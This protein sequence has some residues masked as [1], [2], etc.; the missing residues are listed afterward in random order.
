[1]ENRAHAIAAGLFTL[2]LLAGVVFSVWW[3]SGNREATREILL[4]AKSRVNGLSIQSQVRFRGLRVGKVMSINI[5]PQPPHRIVVRARVSSNVP[6][7]TSSTA[8][9][10][11]MGVT[12]LSFVQ[13]D[14]EGDG[15]PRPLGKEGL[16]VL[17]LEPSSVES[18]SNSATELASHLSEVAEKLNAFLSPTNA[19]RL[20]RT[21]AHLEGMSAGLEATWKQA[22]LLVADLRR[23]TDDENLRRFKATLANLDRAGAEVTPLM[24]KA[25]T[26]L[27]QM[28]N[29][30]R[31]LDDVL[32]E[33]GGEVTAATL[34]RLNGSLRDLSVTAREVSLLAAELRRAPQSIIAGR[35][36]PVPGPGEPGFGGAR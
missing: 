27:E 9:L 30:A 7:T 20:E 36:P 18:L 28:D 23:V 10:N 13:L 14:D 17:D 24:A 6:I 19:A 8:Q 16:P 33:T 31:R 21:L 4:V 3:L 15:K 11:T 35:Q 26:T 32:A 1:M 34:P 2:L 25:R 29:L 5:E 22:P 12:G